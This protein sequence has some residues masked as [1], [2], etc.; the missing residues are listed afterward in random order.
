MGTLLLNTSSRT[1]LTYNIG[2]I[3]VTEK[4][5]KSQRISSVCGQHKALQQANTTSAPP[6]PRRSPRL[7]RSTTQQA[8]Q[9][10][11]SEPAVERVAGE[12]VEASEELAL[13]ADIGELPYEMRLAI[14]PPSRVAAG[15][16][17]NAPLVVT[18]D[19]SKLRQRC[20]PT[21]EDDPDI[22]GLF[23]FLSLVTEDRR[24]SLAPPQNQ[25]VPD[26]QLMLGRKSDSVH[27]ANPLDPDQEP[28]DDHFAWASF[29][30]IAITRPGRYC[31]K[32]S[33]IDLNR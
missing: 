13:R 4:E 27:L 10:A 2:Q 18:F 24:Q 5:S 33:V 21:Q 25:S 22:S 16:A 20:D 7:L 8:Y 23:A 19:A 11:P 15:V 31:F 14:S 6:P 1:K 3:D 9:T 28:E 29:S 30:D 12:A 32:I 26:P 17:L